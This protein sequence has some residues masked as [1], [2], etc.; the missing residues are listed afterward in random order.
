MG[1]L[2]SDKTR[3]RASCTDKKNGSA[4]EPKPAS[5]CSCVFGAIVRQVGQVGRVGVEKDYFSVFGE[6]DRNLTS[7][8]STLVLRFVFALS[9]LCL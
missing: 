7:A 1:V 5:R 8:E 6:F 4:R 3:E 2:P 9:P